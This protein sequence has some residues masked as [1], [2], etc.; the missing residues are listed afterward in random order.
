MSERVWNRS[1]LI[2]SLVAVGI[3]GISLG[4]EWNSSRQI[5]ARLS[6]FAL[7]L[8]LSAACTS[9]FI[10]ILRFYMLLAQSGVPISLPNT[11]LAQVVGFALSIMPGSVGDVFKLHLIQERAG[12]SLLRTAPALLL[13]RVME[14]AG[15]IVLA[16]VSTA[17]LPALQIH[18]PEMP[19]LAMGLG[20]LL[21][22]VLLRRRFGLALT[23]GQKWLGKFSLGTR[24]L[25]QVQ[26]MRRDLKVSITPR[27]LVTGLAL[28]GLARLVDGL[29]LLLAAQMLDV[30]LALPVAIFV[31]AA[32][33]L[34]GG[35]SLLPGG[36]GAAETTMA[37]L[38]MF[39]GAPL[40]NALAIT[41]VARLSTLWLWVALGLAL[42]FVM[43]FTPRVAVKVSN[44][45]LR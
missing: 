38:L 10:R 2:A 41:L 27:Q 6:L 15:F 8:V 37:G 44:H 40:A 11:A 24:L 19:L 43:Q 5:T 31:V 9:Y 22:L 13:D 20:L 36:A 23:F 7:M 4:V 16:L 29:V 30:T 32:S 35:V 14:G 21:A 45:S 12:T 1:L 42:T 25:A 39:S 17:A 33:G 34:A 26:N 18:L 3:S 28:T